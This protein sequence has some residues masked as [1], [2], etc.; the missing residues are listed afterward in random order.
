[1]EEIEAKV[2]E[3]DPEEIEEKLGNIGAEK[4]WSYDIESEF[5]D[6]PD[7]RIEENGLLRVR[8]REDKTFVTRKTDVS[9][10]EAKVMEETE[11]EIRDRSSFK[12]FLKSLGLEKIKE[13]S[14]HRT[15]WTRGET[16]FV[17]DKIPGIPPTL[18][19]E[20]PSQEKLEKGFKDLGFS[21]NETVNWGAKRMFEE[22]DISEN[23]E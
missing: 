19:V 10:D 12:D 7:G 15:K 16:E 13:S 9:F 6:F 17:I 20:S 22:Y 3:I 4:Q 18:E 1:M 21:M 14:K 11:F 8:W 23:T 2:L 5:F